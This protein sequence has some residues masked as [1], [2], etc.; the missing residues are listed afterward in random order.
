MPSIR[1]S[2]Q[3]L[4]NFPADQSLVDALDE[5]CR[6]AGVSKSQFIRDAIWEKL[7]ADLRALAARGAPSRLGK[8]GPK[9]R[10]RAN[11][12]GDYPEHREEFSTAEERPSS[13]PDPDPKGRPRR[14]N[15]IHP[16]T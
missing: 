11:G 3:K 10:P 14:L 15:M 5:H 16:S 13:P 1:S 12:K 4:V 9:S 7:P 2:G 6:R 8:G